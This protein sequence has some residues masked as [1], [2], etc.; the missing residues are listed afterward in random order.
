MKAYS[1]RVR[2]LLNAMTTE[3]KAAQLT[4]LVPS[5][6]AEE[7]SDTSVLTGPLAQLG[8]TKETACAAGSVLNTVSAAQAIRLQSE[9]LEK[10]RL[11]V[12]LL[13]MLDVIH[14]FRTGFPIPLA[15]ACAFDPGLIAEAGRVMAREAAAS[16]VH[17]TFAPMCDIVRD[18]RWGRVMES[19]GEDPFLTSVCVRAWVEGLRGRAGGDTEE[20]PGED[21]LAVCLKHFIGYGLSEGGRDYDVTDLSSWKLHETYLPPFCAGLDA[22]ADMVM[23]AFCTYEG[24]PV[25]ANRAV[26]ETIL[27]QEMGFDG[28]LISDWAAIQ[29]ICTHGAAETGR[30]AAE[31]AFTAGVDIDMMAGLYARYLPSLLAEGRIAEAALDKAVARVLELKERL[32]LFEHPLRAADAER[33]QALH[34]CP[35]HR[36]AAHRAA[37]SSMVLL[38]NDGILP[39]SREV[40][41]VAVIGPLGDSGTLIGAWECAVREEE[42]VT[43]LA[44]IRALLPEAEVTYEPGCGWTESVEGGVERAVRLAARCDVVVLALGECRDMTG[45]AA[46]RADIALPEAQLELARAVARANPCTAAALFAGRPLLLETLAESLP[47]LWMCWMP[48]TQGGQAAAELLFG[49][50][51]PSGRLAMTFP[52]HE[53]QI[54]LYYARYATGRPAKEGEP[55]E[56][57][58]VGYQDMPLEPLYPFGFG[59]SYTTFSY[60]SVTLSGSSLDEDGTLRAS[61]TVTNTGN[62]AGTE[63]AQ[64]YI[65][66]LAG[67]TIRPLRELKGFQKIRLEPG[68]SRTVT[69]D[70]T[71]DTLRCYT[72]AGCY[73]AEPGRFILYAGADATTTNGVTF[74]YRGKRRADHI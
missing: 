74:V 71:A 26:M 46:S 39:F 67:S 65:R 13:L 1:H 40:R 28:P 48:G 59:L 73:E 23:T 24:V 20:A 30:E 14:G 25:T 19:A 27:R 9:Y 42:A 22:G 38:K 10:N 6:I 57:Y 3:E 17:V 36:E 15:M 51:E 12:P 5:M 37:L 31:R 29:E 35:A 34:L 18:P 69:F 55:R 52:R 41:S 58:T 56:R 21:A 68:N 2:T 43:L 50:A 7:S 33:E 72:D 53:G 64:W 54:P 11:G 47:A 32:G 61:V 62:R 49:L 63:T 8:L 45:E 60:N 16:G 66:D 70:I 44:G 4:Q